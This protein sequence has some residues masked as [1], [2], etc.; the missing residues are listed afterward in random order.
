MTWIWISRFLYL[1]VLA[2]LTD[3]PN[4]ISSNTAPVINI[5]DYKGL[6]WSN[7]V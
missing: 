3:A 4:E 7:K 2:K 6:L 5:V 1:M